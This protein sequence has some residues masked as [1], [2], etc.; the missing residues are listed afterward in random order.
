LL[1]DVPVTIRSE[2]DEPLLRTAARLWQSQ[3]KTTKARNLL[4]PVYN[5]FTNV[6]DT[7]ELKDALSEGEG[8]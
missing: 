3:G 7:A 8:Q 5:W 4:A 1:E 2:V 6:F